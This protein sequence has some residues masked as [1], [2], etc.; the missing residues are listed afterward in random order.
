M[1]LLLS[2]LLCLAGLHAPLAAADAKLNVF[3]WSEY[4]DPEV[5]KEFERAQGCK[6]T[7]DVYE[8]AESMLAKLQGGGAALYDVVVPPD[9]M[10]VM[11]DNRGDSRDS[12]FHL[13]V[14]NGAV[15]TDNVVGRVVL[16]VW[17]FSRFAT[18]PVPETFGT[19]PA[20][21]A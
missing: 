1:R 15:P 10:F 18:L 7:V 17:P 11:G 13:E 3:I 14:D 21:K 16:V 9:S 6:V 4:L 5:V 2:L 8:E 19:V 12:R 20:P